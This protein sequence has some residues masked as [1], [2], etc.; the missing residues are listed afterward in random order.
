MSQV[1]QFLPKNIMTSLTLDGDIGSA[2]SVGDVINVVTG[3]ATDQAGSSV[4]F[5]GAGNTL[6]LQVTDAKSNTIIGKSS[7]RAG[8]TGFSNVALGDNNLFSLTSG[9]A[10]TSVGSYAL[11][12]A[13]VSVANCAFGSEAL[14]DLTIGAG[15]NVAMGD[16]ALSNATTGSFNTSLGAGSGMYLL[17][18]FSNIFIGHSAGFN[19]TSSEASNILIGSKGIIGDD[20]TLRIG[21]G[22]GNI[23]NLTSSYIAGINGVSVGDTSTVVTM[24]G[25]SDQ[26]GTATLTAGTGITITP[27]ANTI[28]IANS[29]ILGSSFVTDS[30][31]ATPVG[32]VLDIVAGQFSA[33][34]G[35]SVEFTGSTNVVTLNVTDSSRNTIIGYES[36]AGSGTDNSFLGYQVGAVGS[37]GSYNSFVGCGGAADFTSASYNCGLGYH[38]L[39]AITSGQYCVAAGVNAGSNYTSTESSNVIINAP[40]TTGD[41]NMLRIGAGTGTGNQQLANAFIS[42]I[43]G[44]NVS[45]TT[46]SVVTMTSGS[47]QLGTATITAG[48]GISITP[49][50]N[51]ITVAN[52][53]VVTVDGDTGSVTGNTITIHASGLGGSPRI[54][55]AGTT[56]TINATDANGNTNMGFGTAVNSGSFNTSFGQ[57]ALGTGTTGNFNC[58]FGYLAGNHNTG[59][60]GNLAIGY[61]CLRTATAPN[62]C[63]ALGYQ[64]G[65]S[66]TTTESNNICLNSV[67]TVGESNT[68]HIGGGTGTGTR[69]LSTA[70][71]SGINGVNVSSATKTVVTMTSGSDQLGTAV[72][73]AGTGISVTAGANTITIATASAVAESFVTDSGTATPS[74]GALDIVAGQASANCGSS[75]EFTGATN[76]VTLN[77][78]DANRNTILG[79]QSYAGSGTDN[80]FIGY[81]VGRSASTGS[82]N[83]FAGCGGAADFTSASYNCGLGYHALVAVTSGQYSV[84]LGAN[85]GSNYTSSESSNIVINAPGTVSDSNMLRIGAGTGTGNQQLANAFISGINGVNVSSST[86]TVVTMTSGSDQLG[87]ATLTAGTGISITPTANTITISSSGA[88]PSITSVTTSPYTVLS[89]DYFLAVTTSSIAITIL[90]PNAPSTSTVYVVK[91]KTGNASTNNITVT[92]VGGT[93]LIDGS[94][95]FTMN[96]PYESITVIFDGVGYEIW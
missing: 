14:E 38:A 63:L 89:S 16:S 42:G 1:I 95:T 24:T 28:T 92:T 77:L 88:A 43:N 75:V 20:Y 78:T 32:G 2:T 79:Y 26:L 58:S 45:S 12:K 23:D 66:Y 73:T 44:V 47:D 7:G 56:L 9:S 18:G 49:T 96:T 50:A 33:N 85:A 53:G 52:S 60:T 4:L 13:T 31:T 76:V 8:I 15:Y 30:G 72:I 21:P 3:N 29:G 25:G 51:T 11:N 71:I 69:Q 27:T 64:S 35:S 80:S 68:L 19:L 90:L 5:S 67:G 34:C 62:F 46:Q 39:A 37:S 55:A 70:Y 65:Q 22:I 91:D 57:S 83:S 40:G 36:Y 10:N 74:T 17:T 41:S 6:T 61:E 59:G 94:A 82:Y 86:H 93:V 54:T 48:T 81:Q 84:A 87:T